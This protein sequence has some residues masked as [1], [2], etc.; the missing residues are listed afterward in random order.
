MKKFL[1]YISLVA[2]ANLLFSSCKKSDMADNYYN[3]EKAVTA[4][5]PRLYAGLFY[6]E[7]VLPRYWNLYTFQIPVLGEYSQTAGY[8]NGKGIYEQPTNYTGN[9]WDDFY[10]SV[11]ARYRELEKWYN[12][13]PTAAEKEGYKLFLETARIFVYDQ[14]TQMVDMWGDIPFSQ[15]GGL[16]SNGKLT[17]PAYDKG[18]DI[19][20]TALTEL[21]RISDYLATATPPS[22]YL[23][24][25]Q[26]YDYVNGGSLLKWRKYANDLQLR[27]AMRISN[28]DE[29][30]AKA[31]VQAILSNATQYPIS[32]T[33]AE[34]ITIQPSSATAGLA[35]TDQNEI[36]N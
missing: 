1:I 14:A 16:N 27:L 21:K 33:A 2:S 4:D 18:E 7:K 25:L 5:V 34:S 22:F 6:N 9:R 8:T 12:A 3:P 15:A 19:Y 30:K 31:L 29:A 26:S 23:T 24:Q 32:E 10:S 35:P 17:P 13:L 20:N 28:K 36:R 11:I